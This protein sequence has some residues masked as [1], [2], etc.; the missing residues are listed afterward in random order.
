MVFTP[1]GPI[2]H[3]ITVTDQAGFADPSPG[4]IALAEKHGYSLWTEIPW[5]E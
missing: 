3:E 2:G 1:I 5:P 4:R